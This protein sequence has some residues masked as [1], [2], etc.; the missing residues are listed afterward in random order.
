MQGNKKAREEFDN[1][2]S[3]YLCDNKCEAVFK[4]GK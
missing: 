3:H 4:I 1:S 2:K